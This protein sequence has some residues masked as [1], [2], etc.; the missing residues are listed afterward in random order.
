MHQAVLRHFAVTGS[1]P[2]TAVLEPVTTAGRTAAEVL[3]ELAREDFLTLG[4]DGRIRAAYPFSA[5]PTPHRVTIAGGVQVWSMCAIDALGIPAMLGRDA[6]IASA[7][8]VTGE[9]ITVTSANGQTVS[10]RDIDGQDDLCAEIDTLNPDESDFDEFRC[11][12]TI[13]ARTEITPELRE[14]ILDRLPGYQRPDG[15]GEA[16]GRD[17][18]PQLRRTGRVRGPGG[19]YRADGAEQR[20]GQLYDYQ[21]SKLTAPEG[22]RHGREHAPAP[23]PTGGRGRGRGRMVARVGPLVTSAAGPGAESNGRRGPAASARTGA[24]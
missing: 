8:P 20:G 13:T 19:Q 21:W 22:G 5:V 14:W 12:S 18:A 9:T 17:I 6:V 3:A 7:D 10:I 11:S 2:E 15:P 24:G 1:A 23:G 4:P 16:C